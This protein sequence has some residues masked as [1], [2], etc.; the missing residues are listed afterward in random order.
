[1]LNF[2]ILQTVP[3]NNQQTVTIWSIIASIAAVVSAFSAFK[4]RGYAKK[5]FTLASQIYKDRQSNFNLYLV[6]AYRYVSKAEPKRKFLLFHIT[7]NNKSD[8]KSSFRADLEIE[9]IKPDQTVARVIV[10]HDENHNKLISIKEITLFTNDIR[11]EEKAMQTKWLIFEQPTTV[12]VDHKI[13]K[14]TVKASDTHGNTESVESVMM[15]E[16]NYE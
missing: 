12:F 14:Y 16:L 15:K 5:S 6:N 4:S 1:M 10:P 11:I 3:Q 8:S 7:L 2:I 13:E 9:Y